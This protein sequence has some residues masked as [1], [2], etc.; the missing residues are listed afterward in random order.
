MLSRGGAFD[1]WTGVELLS[2]GFLLAPLAALG[3]LGLA[4]RRGRA[5]LG[6]LAFWSM[7]FV[8]LAVAQT[9]FGVDCAP[10]LALALAGAS[11]TGLDFVAPRRRR[12]FAAAAAALG[13]VLCL[14]V[15]DWYRSR[16]ASG[17]N[18]VRRMAL[19]VEA[20][21]WLRAHSPPTS[22]WLAPGPPPE[23][24]V[25]GPWGWGHTLRYAAQRP[26]AGRF[27]GDVES[28][29]STPPGVLPGQRFAGLAILSACGCATSSY[30]TGSGTARMPS[31]LFPRLRR[32][33]VARAGRRHAPRGLLL[34]T[35]LVYESEPLRAAARYT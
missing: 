17:G 2:G 14:P 13:I 7:A 33:T 19:T 26:M 31:S 20:G 30:P 22:G 12:L 9:R 29:A 35:R 15:L 5:D 1:L 24:G 10:A 3:L 4:A 23:Y 6:V 16:P 11:G 25:L 34:S 27:G 18:R 28:K 21:R 8:A 32:Q